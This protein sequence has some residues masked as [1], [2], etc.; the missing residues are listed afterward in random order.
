LFLILLVGALGFFG[1]RYA[2]NMGWWLEKP[3]PPLPEEAVPFAQ[4]EQRLAPLHR[5]IGGIRSGDWRD[6]FNEPHQT[7]S[8]YVNVDPVTPTP[9]RYKL[10]ILPLGELD[11]GHR[12]IVYLTAEYLGIF[13]DLPVE[14][15]DPVPLSEVPD[16]A[17]RVHPEWGDRQLLTSYILRN[18]LKKR[19][20][21][22]AA[23]LLCLTGE[24][25]WPGEGWNFVFGQAQLAGRVG[26]W[27]MYRF[28]DPERVF[29][30]C[31]KRTLKT[32]VHETGHMF[33]M[34]HCT[35]WECC[36]CGS[37]NLPEADR[38]PLWFCPE[39]TAKVLWATG[40]GPIEHFQRLETF[41]RGNG[42]TKEAEFY[43]RSAAAI[44]E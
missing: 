37:N 6:R 44:A 27:S 26:V 23:A 9:E 22:D 36:M 5:Q 38:R 8:K 19:M 40:A 32:A 14:V 33:S 1:M 21:E 13:Y 20:P 30:L 35:A 25:L 29:D 3:D 42:L 28:G 31:L 43:A 41:C 15:M 4:I 10:Y 11:E 34:S 2:E 17:R 12:R 39:C 24:D 18:V 7:F 16:R